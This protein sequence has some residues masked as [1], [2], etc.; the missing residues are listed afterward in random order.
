MCFFLFFFLIVLLANALA[1]F[2][3]IPSAVFLIFAEAHSPVSLQ[4]TT[5][6]KNRCCDFDLLGI[7][8]IYDNM[9]KNNIIEILIQVFF[10]NDKKTLL[11]IG[12]ENIP[13]DHAS[14]TFLFL[15]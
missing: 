14:D 7:M 2:I 10:A 15:V 6:P 5:A 8:F 3:E 1:S 4:R 12:L 11:Y 13:K 9:L